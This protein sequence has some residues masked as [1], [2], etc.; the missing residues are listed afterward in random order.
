M[1]YIP[2]GFANGFLVLSDTSEFAYKLTDYYHPEDE[3]GIAW[4][5]E[6]IGI[7]IKDK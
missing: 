3:D 1:I 4:D 6:T 5:D 7:R 2:E